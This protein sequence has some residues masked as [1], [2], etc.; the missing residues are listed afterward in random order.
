MANNEILRNK[1]KELRKEIKELEEKINDT[2]KIYYIFH[3]EIEKMR[4]RLEE[5]LIAQ[6]I[7]NQRLIKE[8]TVN[9]KEN[10]ETQKLIYFHLGK[11]HGLEKEVG[12]KSRQLVYTFDSSIIDNEINNKFIIQ[13]EDL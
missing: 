8:I 9:L 4:K 13:E 3:P 7:E 11:L 12:V 10:D 5:Y 6:R 1:I 2:S